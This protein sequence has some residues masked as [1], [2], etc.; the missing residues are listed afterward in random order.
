MHWVKKP[1]SNLK[2]IVFWFVVSLQQIL[3]L[4]LLLSLVGCGSTPSL[5]NPKIIDSLSS[6]VIELLEGEDKIEIDAE[7]LAILA[8]VP[9]ISSFWQNSVKASKIAVFSPVFAN[10]ALYAADEEGNLIRFDPVTGKQSWNIN[11]EHQLSGGVGAG[12]GMVLV[13]TFKG[14][15]LAFDESGNALWKAI[16]TSEVLSPPRVDSNIVVVRTGDGRIFGLD[17]IDGSRKWVYQGATPSLTVRSSAGVLISRGAV[18]AGFA[19]G[20]L[21]AMSLFNGNIGWEIA[22]SLP[23]GVTELERM[24]D[25]TSLPVADE[26]LV[27]TVAYQGRVACFGMADGSQV[28][29]RE[30][31]SSIGLAMDD[32][33][34]YVS[35]DQG[36]VVAYDKRSGASI[37]KQGRLGSRKLSPPLVRGH[38][39]IVGDDQ[40]NITL[41]RNYDGAI[42]ARSATDK[43][44]ILASPEALPDG[45][46]VQTAKGGLYAF[47]HQF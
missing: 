23:R 34:V 8:A 40:G 3:L 14:E 44:A 31:S 7:E 15:V 13:G 18:F 12:D 30:A 16:V 21:A 1:S 11:T 35:E 32:D 22:V 5:F 36:A 38:N 33:Y 6:Q 10:G 27:C 41:L 45:F 47:S 39:V 29:T 42:V 4:V 17:A 37:W 9:R 28:W 24:T 25:I 19:G 46:V 26:H 43:S 2:M 20:K